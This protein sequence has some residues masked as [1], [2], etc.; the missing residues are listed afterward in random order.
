MSF[1][2]AAGSYFMDSQTQVQTA[3]ISGFQTRLF[4]STPACW[5]LISVLLLSTTLTLLANLLQPRIAL[6]VGTSPHLLITA[7]KLGRSPEIANICNLNELDLEELRRVLDNLDI[8]LE[9][10][11][12]RVLKRCSED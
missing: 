10:G 6:Q 4:V 12:L 7:I 5:A 2:L 1:Q 9:E 11:E 8:G 3:F